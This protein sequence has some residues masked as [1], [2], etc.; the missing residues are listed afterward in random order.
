MRHASEPAVLQ[1]IRQHA[2]W[3]DQFFVPATC[4]L[5]VLD[6]Q[7]ETRFEAILNLLQNGTDDERLML[8]GILPTTMCLP[9]PPPHNW[10]ASYES[11]RHSEY[12]P[13]LFQFAASSDPNVRHA[14]VNT[15]HFYISVP[16][17]VDTICEMASDSDSAVRRSVATSMG[18]IAEIEPSRLDSDT[19][20]R[21]MMDLMDDGNPEVRFYATRVAKYYMSKP[22]IFEKVEDILKGDLDSQPR[23]G[24]LEAVCNAPF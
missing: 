6:D 24:A 15:I 13:R 2:E 20:Y 16:G 12:I 10:F 3:G 18:S 14:V 4:A 21:T 9:N 1:A 7:P 22:A 5:F 11:S 8:A 23:A 17:V 19:G